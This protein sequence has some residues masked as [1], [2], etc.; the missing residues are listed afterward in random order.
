MSTILPPPPTPLPLPT[1]SPAP[2]AT[3]PSPPVALVELAAGSTVKAE[4]VA[5]LARGLAEVETDV[6]N[7][8]IRS[9][10]ALKVGA[11][12]DLQVLKSGAQVQLAIR[13]IDNHVPPGE[14]GAG[15]GLGAGLQ[16]GLASGGQ[17]GTAIGVQATPGEPAAQNSPS[18]IGGQASLSVRPGP[19]VVGAALSASLVPRPPGAEQPQMPQAV[20]LP[21]QTAT[22]TSAAP[23]TAPTTAIVQNAQ[24][25]DPAG[26]RVELRL[27]SITTAG[28][29]QSQPGAAA[30]SGA[31]PNTLSGTVTAFT[32]TGRPIVETPT[33]LLT[34]DT[35]AD[36]RIGHK[37]TF[38]VIPPAP[39]RTDTAT[40]ATGFLDSFLNKKTWPTLEQAV[41]YL[42]QRAHEAASNTGAAPSTT[43]NLPIPQANSH[44]AHNLMS[45]ANALTNGDIR[46]WLGNLADALEH[47]QP[48]M[49]RRLSDE[50]AQIA[51][52]AVEPR[53][54]DWR[55]ALIPF[56]T[57]TAMEP[58]RMHL[59]GEK[60]PKGE[61]K[62]GEEGSRFII[63]LN[64]SLLG[65]FQL[66]GFMKDRGETKNF[67]LIVRTGAPLPQRMRYDINRIFADFAEVA[68]LRG[69]I[70]FQAQAQFVEV[71][72][73]SLQHRDGDLI[74]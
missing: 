10:I 65:R 21:P 39:P 23:Q 18:T 59:R 24:R 34:L 32:P 68:G 12:L 1:A 38:A 42:A 70:T 13:G 20:Q 45:A 44:L 64:L 62:K 41:T 53:M 50:F 67:D 25:L 57:G 61:K 48:D 28:G 8:Q 11:E 2:V 6:G 7:F 16:G 26:T 31:Q 43:P 17:A 58:V 33:G 9:N 47:D 56:F 35:N 22:G 15:G 19:L 36:V 69:A 29:T 71:P 51:R 63:D 74:A 66:D 30:P 40:G 3:V 55:T 73:P 14:P 4:I 46:A 49:F 5:L 52:I 37:L 72:L 54:D 27:L 60:Q